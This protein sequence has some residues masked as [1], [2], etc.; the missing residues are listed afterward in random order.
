MQ[1]LVRVESSTLGT[2][3]RLA[4]VGG[5]SSW[6]CCGDLGVS[7]DGSRV[8]MSGLDAVRLAELAPAPTL[9]PT[10]AKFGAVGAVCSGKRGAVAAGADLAGVDPTK[11]AGGLSVWSSPSAAPWRVRPH[12]EPVTFCAFANDDRWLVTATTH[13]LAIVDVATRAVRRKATRKADLMFAY[14]VSD[15]AKRIAG[16]TSDGVVH[17]WDAESGRSLAT[18]GAHEGFVDVLA[19]SADGTRLVSG[20]TD[21]TALVWRLPR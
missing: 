6:W 8:V 20:S 15:D 7:R 19:F 16:G 2:V 18:F 21:D 14:A 11:G 9:A 17:L 5:L 13:E 4:P 12:D 1:E 10:L 3:A